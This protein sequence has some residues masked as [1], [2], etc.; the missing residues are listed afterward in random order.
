[1]AKINYIKFPFDKLFPIWKTCYMENLS[2]RVKLNKLDTILTKRMS[3]ISNGVGNQF[4]YLTQSEMLY[5][6]NLYE[7]VI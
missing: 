4:V 3:S 6:K 2:E 7:S 1:M 5:I